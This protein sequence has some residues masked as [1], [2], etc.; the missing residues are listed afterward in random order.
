MCFQ[1]KI[2]II[3]NKFYFIT[4]LSSISSNKL[5]ILN[6]LFRSNSE[7]SLKINSIK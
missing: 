7:L 4:Q 5:L 2:N 3:F 6:K 1:A